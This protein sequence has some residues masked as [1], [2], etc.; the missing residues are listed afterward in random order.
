MLL[1]VVTVSLEADILLAYPNSGVHST[2]E[3]GGMDRVNPDVL[4][5]LCQP[6]NLV[7]TCS[8]KRGIFIACVVYIGLALEEFMSDHPQLL[9]R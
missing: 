7:S 6:L 2:A 5:F 9:D 3:R 4:P 1:D 8:C